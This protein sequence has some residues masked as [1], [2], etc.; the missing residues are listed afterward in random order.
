M[1][2]INAWAAKSGQQIKTSLNMGN[3]PGGT[4][5]ATS[6]AVR[7]ILV[8]SRELAA[9]NFKR[10]AGSA[11]ILAQQLG[12]VKYLVNPITAAVVGLA[13]ALFAAYKESVALTERLSGLKLP[14][15]LKADYVPKFLQRIN[16]A[17]EAQKEINKEVA[18]TAELYNSAAEA[19]KRQ[20]EV[21]KT[22]FDHLRKMNEYSAKTEAEKAK[23]LLQI[24]KDERAQQIKNKQDEWVALQK[25]VKDK[26]KQGDSILVNSEEH[27]KEILKQR[28]KMAE[29]AQ[30]YLD[31]VQNPT[32]SAKAKEAIV[33]GYNAIALTGVSGGDLDKAKADNMAEARRRIAAANSW[34]DTMHENDL[35][36]RRKEELYKDAGNAAKN[37]ATIALAITDPKTGMIAQKRQKDIDEAAEAAAKTAHEQA[38]QTDTKVA[39]GHLTENQR[40]GAYMSQGTS[41]II[42][43]NRR[44]LKELQDIRRLLAVNGP[45]HG[46]PLD[47]PRN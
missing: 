41:T 8:L 26:K 16:A 2:K 37:A 27:D 10:A 34:Q 1:D 22:H 42:D 19:A 24:N 23:A 5:T 36:R 21:T 29:E 35:Q 33:R 13:A 38:F 12:I 43:V 7:E 47:A 6:G 9:G 15:G 18:R 3:A 20:E 40:I 14:E 39:R 45:G 25:E 28:Q 31:Q 32:T 4:H 30:K 17:A 46:P 44:Q 11:T